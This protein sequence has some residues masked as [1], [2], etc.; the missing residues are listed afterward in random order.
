MGDEGSLWEGEAG[1]GSRSKG[2]RKID[3]REATGEEE[4]AEE[5]SEQ[6]EAGRT[7]L[8]GPIN[9][10]SS[11]KSTNTT[12]KMYSNLIQETRWSQIGQLTFKILGQRQIRRIK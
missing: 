4:A 11:F 8:K 1:G 5:A 2:T 10:G 12:E 7:Q 9:Q 6:Q 3:L